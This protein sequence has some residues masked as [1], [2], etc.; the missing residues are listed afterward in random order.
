MKRGILALSTS[1]KENIVGLNAPSSKDL[2]N[3]PNLLSHLLKQSLLTQS[4]EFPVTP[5]FSLSSTNYIDL[6]L[7]I[8]SQ[9]KDD[10][11]LRAEMESALIS[12]SKFSSKKTYNL[13]SLALPESRDM[14]KDGKT[15]RGKREVSA[16]STLLALRDESSEITSFVLRVGCIDMSLDM[17][18]VDILCGGSGG[19]ELF[20]I[21]NKHNV[22]NVMDPTSKLLLRLNK[23][24]V[25]TKGKRIMSL[26]ARQESIGV[27]NF[28]HTIKE[29]EFHV[30]QGN[31]GVEDNVK[32]SSFRKRLNPWDV[33]RSVDY[34]EALNDADGLFE[35]LTFHSALYR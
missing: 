22:K 3:R 16:V 9:N 2:N 25:K 28:Q 30:E 29:Y 6:L 27:R 8:D 35:S 15:K 12:Q 18:S 13:E 11:M 7:P 17:D 20:H 14:V 32:R 26:S 10:S 23:H 4:L 1:D 31:V 24:G 21:R 34:E 33:F 19:R 5:L